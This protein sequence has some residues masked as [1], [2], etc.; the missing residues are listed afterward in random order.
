MLSFFLQNFWFIG[1]ALALV[2]ILIYKQ[3]VARRNLNESAQANVFQCFVLM[4]CLASI[5]SAT[6][7]VL[8]LSAGFPVPL[9][10]FASPTAESL[11]IRASWSIALGTVFLILVFIN[12]R[13]RITSV[14]IA[15]IL[16]ADRLQGRRALRAINVLALALVVF[17][18]LASSL[19]GW[20][21]G[22]I[23]AGPP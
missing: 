11:P 18:V 12:T 8:H 19:A 10:P 17:A 20:T 21:G 3:V 6:I 23:G 22:E 5:S 1:A 2:N 14:Q 13:D 4:F 7:G 9:V 15:E 16:V